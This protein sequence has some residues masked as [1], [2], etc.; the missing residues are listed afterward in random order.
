ML[1]PALF[2][3][4]LVP[5]FA[6]AQQPSRE[7]VRE[8]LSGIEDVPTADEWRRV[9]DGAL[10]V[11]IEL[12]ADAS[13]APFVR[14]RAVGAVAAFPREATR[15]FLLA[16]ASA[17]RQSDLFIREA[18]LALGRAFG[19]RAVTDIRPYLAHRE[20]VVREA[21]ARALGAIGGPDATRALQGRLASEPDLVVRESIEA[22]LR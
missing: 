16:V 19:Q 22:A 17:P 7:R 5:S 15:T 3:L 13:E 14:L 10:P 4:A 1:L 11:L 12:Y 9:G 8:M 18:V 6:S 2:L 21:A 20:S